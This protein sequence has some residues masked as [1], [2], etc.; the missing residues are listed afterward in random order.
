MG[1]GAPLGAWFRSDLRGLVND[2]IL[3]AASPIYEYLRH[4]KVAEL[5]AAHMASRADLSPQIWALLTL[6]SWLR[7]QGDWHAKAH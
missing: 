1:F 4:E 3:D 7:Q 5:L 2:R 6:E